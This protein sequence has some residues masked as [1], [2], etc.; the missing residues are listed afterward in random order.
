MSAVDQLKSLL[1]AER[2][3]VMPLRP[4]QVKSYQ[5]ERKRL[6][7]IVHAP[8]W[9][10]GD[11]GQAQK[12]YRS[13]GAM[14]DQQAPRP[15][16][17]PNDVKRLAD[18]VLEHVIK[19]AM[20]PREVMRRNPVGAVTRFMRQEQGPAAKEAI[21]QWK[22][23]QWALDPTTEDGD[24]TNLERHRPEIGPVAG[25]ST[26]MADAQIPGVFAM[27][28]AAKANWPAAMPA[29][30]TVNSPLRQARTREKK[31]TRPARAPMSAEQ[32]EHLRQKALKRIADL[33]AQQEVERSA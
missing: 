3:P 26:F 19:P 32:R 27:S 1:D 22:R 10:E 30:G 29:E 20:L 8:A 33:K 16:S 31:T 28:P 6:D 17:Q 5:E 14:L 25:A 24:H 13:L 2:H 4:H 12:R 15:A 9:V 11:R 21:Q 23:A 18:E 7:E